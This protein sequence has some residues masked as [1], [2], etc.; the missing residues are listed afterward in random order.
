MQAVA[1]VVYLLIYTHAVAQNQFTKI[2]L[3]KLAPTAYYA[4]SGFHYTCVIL[5]GQQ[6]SFT[7]ML[8]IFKP[9]NVLLEWFTTKTVL[10]ESIDLFS[11]NA[12]L[13][14]DLLY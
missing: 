7:I 4:S 6:N 8:R 1:V 11:W 14:F 10:L 13:H 12:A 5:L 9:R 3:P 2:N